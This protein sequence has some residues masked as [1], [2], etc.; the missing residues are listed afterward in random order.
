MI[1]IIISFLNS[2][3]R[4]TVSLIQINKFHWS[5]ELNK[6]AKMID[7]LIR[8]KHAISNYLQAFIDYVL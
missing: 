1:Y 3:S 6:Y 8:F 5:V 7:M 2:D 4:G